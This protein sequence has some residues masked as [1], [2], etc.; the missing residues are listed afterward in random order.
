MNASTSGAAGS[1]RWP[2]PTSAL[3]ALG[4]A[5]AIASFGSRNCGGESVAAISST[6]CSIAASAA[7]SA[8]S[9][10]PSRVAD[11]R[12]FVYRGAGHIPYATHPDDYVA[13]V[14]AF[15]SRGPMF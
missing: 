7:A 10:S 6:G 11:L 8:L 12:R 9:H 2:P 13:T 1:I 15:I 5:S 14:L 3:R 4:S